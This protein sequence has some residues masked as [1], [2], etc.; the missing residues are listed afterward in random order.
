MGHHTLEEDWG[1]HVS[2]NVHGG[3]STLVVS[4]KALMRVDGHPSATVRG[5]LPSQRKSM[6]LTARRGEYPHASDIVVTPELSVLSTPTALTI[7]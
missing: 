7:A 2:L 5:T 6:A 4:L 1:L 3:Q